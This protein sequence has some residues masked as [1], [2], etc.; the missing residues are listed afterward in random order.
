ML[1]RCSD[2]LLPL[3]RS[4]AALEAEFEAK[5]LEFLHFCI[6]LIARTVLVVPALVVLDVT[7]FSEQAAVLVEMDETVA[8]LFLF[9]ARHL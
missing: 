6:P 3:S 4:S 2:R 8:F 5:D 7:I 1:S 9:D